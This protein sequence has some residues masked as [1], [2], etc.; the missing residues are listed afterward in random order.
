MPATTPHPGAAVPSP[1]QCP[2]PRRTASASPPAPRARPL[3]TSVQHLTGTNAH[4]DRSTDA[5]KSDFRMHPDPNRSRPDSRLEQVQGLRQGGKKNDDPGEPKEEKRKRKRKPRAP[6]ANASALQQTTTFV[7]VGVTAPTVYQPRTPSLCRPLPTPS[8][9]QTC[10]SS[11]EISRFDAALDAPRGILRCTSGT[12]LAASPSR[13]STARQHTVCDAESH[14][15]TPLGEL[16]IGAPRTPL[17]RAALPYVTG[18][19]DDD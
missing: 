10:T 19:P 6:A 13:P 15:A 2:A 7:D 16:R 18:A 9:Q 8:L 5:I 3:S 14:S 17:H 4:S 1:P 12:P 11:R